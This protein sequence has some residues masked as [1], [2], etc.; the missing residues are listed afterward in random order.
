MSL[1]NVE[2]AVEEISDSIT[3]FLA[4]K[5]AEQN[6]EFD[7]DPSKGLTQKKYGWY[8]NNSLF[9]KTHFT[10]IPGAIELS[11]SATGS[12]TARIRSATAGQYRS[13]TLAVPGVGAAVTSG[14]SRDANNYVSLDNGV[15][16]IGAG[17]HDSS[18]GGWNVGGTIQTFIGFKIDSEGAKAV[19]ISDGEHQ[20]GSPVS[21]ENWSEDVLDDSG[22]N[23]RN[24]SG[25]L[26]TPEDGY[27][28]NMPYTWYNQGALVVGLVDKSMNKFLPVHQFEVDGEPSLDRPNLPTNVI[29]DNDGDAAST[30]VELGGMQ[31]SRYGEG[32]EL[33]TRN[34][35]VSRFTSGSFI[36]TAKVTNNNALDPQAEPGSPLVAIRS[37]DQLDDTLIRVP[38]IVMDADADVYLYQWDE[39]DD[40]AALT[41]ENF[42]KPKTVTSGESK[43]EVDT[44]ATDYSPSTYTLRGVTKIE[45]G[46]K[47]VSLG[48]ESTNDK[49]PIRGT[50]VVTVVS[51]GTSTDA[52]PIIV[53]VEEGF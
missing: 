39:Y 32:Q 26:F 20:A 7:I 2:E 49:L 17:W 12:D 16:A 48:V 28:Y 36:G 34:T 13:Q 8:S 14:V 15:V 53:D 51:D 37:E 18:S 31:F 46:K 40:A 24:P 47:E 11:T 44:E 33:P 9:D 1:G 50:R 41:G 4:N 23:R 30:T 42:R 25:Q 29:V 19:L 35:Q 52:Q 43:L 38:K 5:V 21:Q 6:L 10:E 45:G 3:P 27:I 22:A